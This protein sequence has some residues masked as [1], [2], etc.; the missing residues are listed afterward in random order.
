MKMNNLSIVFMGTP[1]FAAESLKALI[2]SRHSVKAVITQPDKPSG[3]GHKMTPPPVKRLALENDIPVYQPQSLKKGE[4]ADS[5]YKILCDIAP[6]VIVVAAYG[7]LLGQNILDL[8]KYG[9]INVHGSLLPKYR[10]AAP[11]QWSIINGEEKTGVTIM[12]M[13][14]GLDSGDMYSKAETDIGDNET[15]DELHDRLAVMGAELLIDTLSRLDEITPQPQNEADWTYAPM[16]SREMSN[17][18][19]SMPAFKVHK[20]ICGLSDWPC[21]QFSLNGKRIKVYKSE[22]IDSSFNGECGEIVDEKNFIIRCGDSKGVRICELQQDGGKRMRAEP[23]LNGNKINK[24][25]K[26]D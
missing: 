10:G 23:F 21:A 2:G 24:G 22:Y 11:I 7:K 25:D 19:F 20:L 14:L 18:D 8:P 9:C 17:I 4:D 15:A 5:I 16:L 12:K 13:E 6:D 26:V 1:D 3:R